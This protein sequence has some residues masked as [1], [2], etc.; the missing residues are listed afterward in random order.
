MRILLDAKDLI[1]VVEHSNPLTLSDFDTW[2]R[3]RNSSLVY[4]LC[5]IRALAGPI[6][7]NQVHLPRIKTYLDKLEEL[8]HSYISA[9][10]DLME[11]RSAIQCCEAGTEYMAVDPYVPRFDQV[12]PPF[13]NPGKR[14]YP[15]SEIVHDL[16]RTCPQI[17]G[18]QQKAYK[19]QTLAMGTDRQK[20]KSKGTALAESPSDPIRE[21]LVA[22][23]SVTAKRADEVAAWVSAK[24]LR[25]PGLWLIRTVGAAMS[26]NTSYR[27]RQDDTFDMAEMMTIPYVD[28]ATVDRTTLDYFSRAK[29]SLSQAGAVEEQTHKVFRNLEKLMHACA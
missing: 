6:S 15:L 5:N 28:V 7:I 20:P 19:L 25:C 27:A 3:K 26:Q 22:K 17:F 12:F 1:N 4:S 11:L 21:T 24:P 14:I 16:W 23:F 10:I 18:V 29:R 13:A 9:Y 2:I 8:P